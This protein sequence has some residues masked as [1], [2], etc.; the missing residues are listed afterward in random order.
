MALVRE[1][2]FDK[3]DEE[4][5]HQCIKPNPYNNPVFLST[6]NMFSAPNSFVA[7]KHWRKIDLRIHYL[8][9]DLGVEY[10][11]RGYALPESERV[12][13]PYFIRACLMWTKIEA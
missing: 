13:A 3:E 7:W 2:Q 10:K 5:L 12:N 8:R 4:L 1:Y 11:M 6:G 9:E